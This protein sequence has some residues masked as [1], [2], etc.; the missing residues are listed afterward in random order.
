MS[1]KISQIQVYKTHFLTNL[2]SQ[3]E[4]G[5]DQHMY[6]ATT[7]YKICA[8]YSEEKNEREFFLPFSIFLILL[9]YSR[10]YLKNKIATHERKE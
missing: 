6:L 3:N 5:D 9:W 2:G 4:K 10:V 1:N 8:I 7:R